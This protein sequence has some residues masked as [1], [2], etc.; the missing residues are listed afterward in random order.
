MSEISTDLYG[1]YRENAVLPGIQDLQDSCWDAEA[2]LVPFHLTFTTDR[3]ST[4]QYFKLAWCI[5]ILLKNTSAHFRKEVCVTLQL[6]VTHKKT[7]D[8]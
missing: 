8:A 4:L 7:T 2:D 5:H 1:L 6:D 3:G